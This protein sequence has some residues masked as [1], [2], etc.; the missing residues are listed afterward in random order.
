MEKGWDGRPDCKDKSN[1]IDCGLVVNDDSYNKSL[2]PSHEE[3]VAYKLIVNVSLYLLSLSNFEAISGS[4]GAKFTVLMSWKDK[5]LHLEPI[6]YVCIY[7]FLFTKH[8]GS[9]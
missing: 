7:P 3:S 9:H 8:R 2:T 4:F 6:D 1:E 5:R